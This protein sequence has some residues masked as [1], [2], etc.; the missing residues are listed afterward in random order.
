MKAT[1]LL[2]DIGQSIW[3]D[4]IT[5][6][7]LDRGTL[8][9]YIRN[10]SS[11][12][13]D[14]PRTPSREEFAGTAEQ[15]YLHCGP[16]GTGH[17]VKMVMLDLAADPLAADPNLSEFAGRISDSDE[18]RWTIKAAIDEAVPSP[19]LTTAL[20]SRFRSRGEPDFANKV[21]ST[22]RCQFGGHHEHPATRPRAV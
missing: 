11:G 16:N 20:Q 2:H 3:L 12:R 13:D 22:M 8:E 14:I 5:R 10:L 17:F 7:L 9:G 6:D 18:G 4:N 1:G 19:A 21:L 15:G